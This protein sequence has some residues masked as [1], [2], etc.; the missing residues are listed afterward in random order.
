MFWKKLDRY[1]N[2]FQVVGL[3]GTK[4]QNWYDPR[5]IYALDSKMENVIKWS[6]F[7]II[8][9]GKIALTWRLTEVICHKP[10]SLTFKAV[11]LK[12]WVLPGISAVSTLSKEQKG[13]WS[14]H[15]LYFAFVQSCKNQIYLH[16][17]EKSL[18]KF[19][20]LL[21]QLNR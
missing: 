13:N 15:H 7:L 4:I 16:I 8:S 1:K 12:R 20:V 18:D 14:L 17:L 2:T 11:I 10:L 19:Y 5:F 21:Y 6:K 9:Q 3:L